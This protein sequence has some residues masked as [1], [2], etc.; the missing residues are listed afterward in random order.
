ALR[1]YAEVRGLVETREGGVRT[2]TWPALGGGV[3]EPV[4]EAEGQTSSET[5]PVK[6]SGGPATS[7]TEPVKESEQLTTSATEPVKKSESPTTSETVPPIVP[8]SG[9][10]PP[11]TTQPTVVVPGSLLVV[12]VLGALGTLRDAH[13]LVRFCREAVFT[14]ASLRAHYARAWEA[15]VRKKEMAARQGAGSGGGGTT[16]AARRQEEEEEEEEEDD[17][18]E[19]EGVVDGEASRPPMEEVDDGLSDAPEGVKDPSTPLETEPFQGAY[20]AFVEGWLETGDDEED[21]RVLVEL[22]SGLRK[23]E[24]RRAVEAGVGGGRGDA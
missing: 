8:A 4:K 21:T 12:G 20:M 14:D 23:E 16:A 5:E 9:A 22:V 13:G 1:C 18:E 6:K 19:E 2:W 11:P 10:S 24:K 3:A 7:E 17:G 15:H